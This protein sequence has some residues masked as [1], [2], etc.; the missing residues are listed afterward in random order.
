[1][2]LTYHERIRDQRSKRE[3]KQNLVD[4]TAIGDPNKSTDRREAT[5]K[6][7]EARCSADGPVPGLKKPIVTIGGEL[8]IH[9]TKP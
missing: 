4:K 9:P 7:P 5:K 2:K 1:V 3:E 6:A 8:D